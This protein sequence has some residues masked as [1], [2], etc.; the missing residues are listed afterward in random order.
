MYIPKLVSIK[1]GSI[2]GFLFRGVREGLSSN[3]IIET[4]KSYDYSYR[5][6]TMLAD[7][8]QYRV[9]WEKDQAIQRLPNH[10]VPSED[11]FTD[12]KHTSIDQRYVY[13]YHAKFNDLK[14]GEE[15]EW[16]STAGSDSLLT[17]G[18]INTQKEGIIKGIEYYKDVEFT[19]SEVVAVYR[20]AK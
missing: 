6:Q 10:V 1:G 3:R 8:R 2:G 4:L 19:V 9:A 13:T 14:T 15:R 7:I 12:V 5:R 16:Y 18:Q 20:G 11:Y 17:K